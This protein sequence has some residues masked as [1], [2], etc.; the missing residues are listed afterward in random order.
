MGWRR[1][2][3]TLE[4]SGVQ[5]AASEPVLQG[6][7]KC[8]KWSNTYGPWGKRRVT[9]ARVLVL[10][11]WEERCLGGQQVDG[12]LFSTPAPWSSITLES[13]QDRQHGRMVAVLRHSRK[14]LSWT[15]PMCQGNFLCGMHVVPLFAL[16]QRQF[17]EFMVIDDSKLPSAVNSFL[18]VLA[19]W[20]T[21]HI[22]TSKQQC[23]S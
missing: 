9:Q 10:F 13:F 2:A 20:Q 7:R 21:G 17:R 11:T 4:T 3:V 5:I 19:L 22:N 16:V 8:T 14:A 23:L 1:H 12:S 15:P 6:M 18:S